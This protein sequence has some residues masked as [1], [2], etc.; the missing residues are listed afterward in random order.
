MLVGLQVDIAVC[1]HGESP[2]A[3]SAEN[4]AS[5]TLSIQVHRK[6]WRVLCRDDCLCGFR[7][8]FLR[9]LRTQLLLWPSFKL[10]PPSLAASPPLRDLVFTSHTH[11]GYSYISHR[12]YPLQ[13]S[14]R[15]SAELTEISSTVNKEHEESV[16]REGQGLVEQSGLETGDK[17]Q[18]S[19]PEELLQQSPTS[20][21][22]CWTDIPLF[23]VTHVPKVG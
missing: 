1:S 9:Y 11:S 15:A 17:G 3:L 23:L 4:V 2:V 13:T 22:T 16:D 18:V 8:I 10:S 12:I 14:A 6:H 21:Y 7:V 19:G 20:E 5:R